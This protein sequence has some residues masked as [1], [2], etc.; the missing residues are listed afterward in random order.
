[1][2]SKA[3]TLMGAIIVFCGCST[4]KEH[5]IVNALAIKERNSV[6]VALW[7][8][9]QNGVLGEDE[10]NI[11]LGPPY[12]EVRPQI[13]AVQRR[14]RALPEDKLNALDESFAYHCKVYS[15]IWP[16]SYNWDASVKE[17][18]RRLLEPDGAANGSQPIR[19][20][21]NSTPSAAGSRR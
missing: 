10:I 14:V 19:S 13:R 18:T 16:S 9:Q 17:E 5:A 15:P 20:E 11:D 3:F 2:H 6:H 12:R 1:M 7:T 4:T 21:T 8:L